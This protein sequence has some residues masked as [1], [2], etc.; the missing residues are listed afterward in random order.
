MILYLESAELAHK[1]FCLLYFCANCYFVLQ[2]VVK[3]LYPLQSLRYSI[4]I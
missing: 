3:A 4:K 1:S 2:L